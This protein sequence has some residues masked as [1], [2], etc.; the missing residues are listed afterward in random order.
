M[1]SMR[2]QM[3]LHFLIIYSGL[4]IMHQKTLNFGVEQVLVVENYNSW[5]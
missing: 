3:S 1:D 2:E 4:M 5:T